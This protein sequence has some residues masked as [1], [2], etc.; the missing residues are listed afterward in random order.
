[1]QGKQKSRRVVVTGLGV[2]S[3]FGSDVDEFY[4]ALL[5]GESG[6]RAIDSFPCEEYPTRFAA[7]VQHFSAENYL[8]KKQLRRVDPFIAYSAVAG[9][10]ALEQAQFGAETALATAAQRYGILIGSGMGGMS[11]FTDNVRALHERGFQRVSPFF[12]PYILTN[13]ASGL[14]AMDLG[15]MGPNYA[16]STACAS[17]NHA[18]IA[19]ANHIRR[20][21]A[22][23]M[24][25]GGA[26]AGVTPISL[27]GF[28]ALKALSRRNDAPQRASRPW[29]KG[30]DGFVIGEGAGMLVL[31]SLEHALERGAPIL[32]EYC[33]GAVSCDAHHITEPRQDGA[34]I[35]NC[36]KQALSD[37]HLGA[38][39]IDFISAHATATPVG[40]MVEI[41]ALKQIFADPSAIAI[42]AAKSMLGHALGAAPGLSAV[43]AVKAITSGMIP[44]TNNLEEP[45]EGLD[46]F[47]P[48]Q[49]HQRPVRGVLSNAFGFGGHNSAVIFTPYHP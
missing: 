22:D 47:V 46:F 17:G 15:F 3:C 30:R 25:C 45:E 27:A 48:K 29:D 42:C 49:M 16:I 9:K 18:I 36:V 14:L 38:E 5:R 20:H 11:I 2:V 23:L 43:I 33:G 24:L 12:I 7:P 32:A 35:V 1:M 10:K 41:E 8:D 13:M 31:E 40:D 6:M 39:A 19:A 28:T 26:E 44:P 21:E 4:A 37:G 34:G